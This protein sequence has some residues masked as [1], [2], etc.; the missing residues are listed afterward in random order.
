MTSG[1]WLLDMTDGA[2]VERYLAG[3]GLVAAGDLPI[4]IARAGAGNMNLTIRI[5]TASGRTFV[6]KQG[7]PWVEKYP[8]IPA[9]FERTLV[10]AAFYAAVARD[11]RVSRVMPAV[12]D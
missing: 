11:P 1:P 7:R 6:V 9:P 5:T 10:E 4:T 3:R 2:G 12:L 8:Q